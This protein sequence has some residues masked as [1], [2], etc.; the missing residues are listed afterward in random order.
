VA[1]VQGVLLVVGAEGNLGIGSGARIQTGRGDWG[2][3]RIQVVVQQ[4]GRV[5]AP[6]IEHE[7]RMLCEQMELSIFC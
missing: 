3:Q 6:V 1:D 2:F 7:E 4:D 5:L